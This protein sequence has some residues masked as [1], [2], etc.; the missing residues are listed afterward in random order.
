MKREEKVFEVQNLSAKIK[1]AKTIAL[2]DFRGLTVN[3]LTQLREKV[4]EVG[5]ELQVVKNT[6][7]SRALKENNY[8]IEKNQLQGTNL[9]LFANSDEVS[10]L[11]T[12]A[13]FGKTLSLLP[14]KIG[15]M[16]G[17]LLS[18]E[19]LN[20][21]ANLPT[22]NELQAKLVGLLAGQ[23]SRLVYALNWNLQK[24]VL[25]LDQVKNKKQ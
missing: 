4:R 15:F 9:V 25:V 1:G 24:L 23:P 20:R 19:E 12:L 21:F 10:P 3:Q 6:L 11:K 5:G 22:K 16:A 8:P 7:F 2:A 13:N 18:A 17:A 14:L